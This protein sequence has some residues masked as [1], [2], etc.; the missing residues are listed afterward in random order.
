MMSKSEKEH[1]QHT[2][3]SQ[4]SLTWVRLTQDRFKMNMD[5]AINAKRGVI[6]F[7]IIVRDY[8]GS[9]LM[10][11]SLFWRQKSTAMETETIT[12]L[13]GLLLAK[14][15]GFLSLKVESDA[16]N[17]VKFIQENNPNYS[18]VGLL[19]YDILDL[20]ASFL[21]LKFLFAPRN[22]NRLPIS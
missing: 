15:R 22:Y 10:A 12:I 17:V 18:G 1:R 14:E 20:V 9:V 2:P 8:S 7:G 16:L 5:V 21:D 13:E 6:G 11:A 3:E 4:Q 19:I